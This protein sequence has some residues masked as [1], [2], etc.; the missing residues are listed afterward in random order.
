MTGHIHGY[1]VYSTMKCITT[2][3]YYTTNF[4]C[5]GTRQGGGGPT[6]ALTARFERRRRVMMWVSAR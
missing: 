2:I 6:G 5:V 4:V 1:L 3:Q